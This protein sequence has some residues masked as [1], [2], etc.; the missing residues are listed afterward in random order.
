MPGQE[1]PGLDTEHAHPARVC[2]YWLGGRERRIAA[3]R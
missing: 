2:N 1:A 3:E